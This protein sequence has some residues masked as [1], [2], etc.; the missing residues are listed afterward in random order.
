MALSNPACFHALMAAVL[1]V[2]RSRGRP[3]S[4]FFWYHRGATIVTL[5]QNLSGPNSQITDAML[6]AVGM[7]AYTEVLLWA[8]LEYLMFQPV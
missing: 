8:N 1:Q 2:Q 6:C 3:H 5:T 4:E 7:L